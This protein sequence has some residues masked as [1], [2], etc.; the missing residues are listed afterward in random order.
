MP[1]FATHKA[2]TGSTIAAHG[3]TRRSLPRRV[4]ALRRPQLETLGMPLE[5][6]QTPL[7][8][9]GD[10]DL[11]AK[12]AEGGM[13]TVYK[14]R[15]KSDGLIV[16]IKI[17]PNT[18]ARNPVLLQRFKREFEAAKYL[19]HRNLVKAIDYCGNVPTP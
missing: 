13:G 17:I 11:L 15:R 3:K 8:E 18:A 1:E 10:Y 7:Q 19:D 4:S 9:I 16:A 2:K 6:S 5:T 12:I 14:G